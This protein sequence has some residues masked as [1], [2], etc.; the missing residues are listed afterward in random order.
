M[1]TS[2]WNLNHR[3]FQNHPD[4]RFAYLSAQ[5][6]E[7]LARL[8]YLAE[9]RKLGGILIGPYGVGKSMVLAL[10]VEKIREMGTSQVV[11][12]DTPVGGVMALAK[13]LLFKLNCNQSV[14]DIAGALAVMEGLCSEKNAAFPHLTLI[15]DEAQL[16]RDREVVE[17]LH[18]LTNMRMLKKDGSYGETAIT[19]ILSG[20]GDVLKAVIQD[21]SFCQRLQLVFKLN[22]LSAQQVMEYVHSRIRA[23]GGD[24]W[25]FEEDVFPMLHEASHGLPR[26]VNNICDVALVLG[27][28]VG[29]RR[30]S[31]A[32][33][34]QAIEEVYIP[35][36]SRLS[37]EGEIK[38]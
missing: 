9:G 1:Y 14:A 26:I 3:P 16:I 22:P 28:S 33:M 5:H 15:L 2:Y 4:H 11:Q 35:A 21:V 7:A 34:R 13:Q 19:V 18:L 27:Y 32:I 17:F 25:C 8:L 6:K 10:L 29:A 20:H 36:F 38:V 24:I 23:A 12:L 37:P 31:Q 30:I